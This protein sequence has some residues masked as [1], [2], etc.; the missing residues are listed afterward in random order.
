VTNETAAISFLRSNIKDSPLFK[1]TEYIA[2]GVPSLCFCCKSL[3]LNELFFNAGF[4]S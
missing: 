2:C 3:I 1:V 4:L